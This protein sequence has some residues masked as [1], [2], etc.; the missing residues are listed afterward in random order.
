MKGVLGNPDMASHAFFYLRDPAYVDTRPG[1]RAARAARAPIVE[2][3]ERV[4]AEEAERRARERRRKLAALKERIRGS[5]FPVHDD[6]PDPRALGELVL[7]GSDRGH[8]PALPRGLRAR[9]AR[10]RGGRA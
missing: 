2:E 8:R 6:Y 4:G 5:G 1:G 3:I 10:S 9:S 7:A